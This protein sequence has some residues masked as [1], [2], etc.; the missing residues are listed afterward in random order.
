MSKMGS[1]DPFG[2]LKHKLWPEERSG[3]KLPISVPII[4]HLESPWFPWVQVA[5]HILLESF[6]QGLQLCFKPHFN[7]NY[8]HKVMGLP[9]GSFGTKWHLGASPLAKHKEYY[10]GEG[11]GCPQVWAMMS[12]TRSCTKNAPVTH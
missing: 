12:L 8:A 10:K 1:H 6:W 3:V 5:S 4:K 2:Y 7:Q 11:G 9:F